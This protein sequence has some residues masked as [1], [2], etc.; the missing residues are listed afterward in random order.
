MSG[1]HII[2][3]LLV[4]DRPENLVALEALLESPRVK[5]TK[6]LSGEEALK[7][8]LKEDYA[9]IL[10]DVQM[11]GLD[12]YETARLI[13]SREK[14]KDTPIIFVTAIN[15]EPEHVFS[16]YTIGAIDYLFKPF[17]P[18]ILK[19]KVEQLIKIFVN[20]REI[21][22]Q[23]ERFQEQTKELKIANQE[24]FRVTC[25]LQKSEALHRLVGETSTDTI[26]IVNVAHE[27]ISINPA[28]EF[29]FGYSMGEVLGRS[30]TMLIPL[31]LLETNEDNQLSAESR[32]ITA[33]SKNG[34]L[35]P[36]EVQIKKCLLEG[37][38]IYVC[39]VRDISESV[40]QMVE[41]QTE[42]INWLETRNGVRR[43]KRD[44]GQTN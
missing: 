36:A 19:T 10:L 7:A 16:G 26:I 33:S 25:E 42:F 11:P 18:D 31:D 32:E 44:Y 21:K 40:K 17:D 8:V 43:V 5:L 24:L 38:Y 20:A 6:C 23:A 29:M 27:I 12:G 28:V 15:K 4:D 37:N 39:T 34:G 9:V 13:K 14:S 35:F 1:D 30:A 41:L 3:I 22:Q 2:N